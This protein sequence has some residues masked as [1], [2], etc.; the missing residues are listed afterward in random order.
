MSIPRFQSKPSESVESR[1]PALHVVTFGCQMN[2]YD[3]LSVEGR[4]KSQ[5]Y[6]TTESIGDADVVL[7]NTCSVRE[8]AEERVYSW[9][10]ELKK[11]K[12]RRPE[13]VV[14]VMGCMAERVGEELFG[15]AP[16][17]DLVVGTRSF[18]HLPELI[19]EVRSVRASGGVARITKLGLDEYPDGARDG[20]EYTGGRLGYLTVMRG[21]DLNCTFC[22]VPR[23]RGR[24]LSRP[25]DE[26]V[27]EARWMVERGAQ[28]ITL[29]GQ[30]V[31]SY[32]ED[33]PADSSAPMRGRQ[34]RPS[35]ADLLYRLQELDGLERIRLI[36]LHPSYVTRAL[37]EALRDCSKCDAFL[38][39]P[40]QAGSDDVLKRMKRGYT[41]DLY[42][43]RVDLLRELVPDI[44]LASDW[45]V[46]FP[47]ESD[48]DFE[49]TERFLG[50]QR[51]VTNYIFQYSPRPQTHAAEAHVDDVSAELKRERNHRL[52]ATAERVQLARFQQQIGRELDCFVERESEKH[53]GT[54]LGHTYTGLPISF[55]G[56]TTLI[57]SH[58]RI[59]V[60]HCT[61]FGLSGALAVTA[62]AAQA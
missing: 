37:A 26:L 25:I 3:S 31:N 16:I 18:Q 10:G 43:R 45:I 17:V 54:L 23:V 34:G 32:G 33:L 60:E 7:F 46:G 12:L 28:V 57:G 21:C 27:L 11:E 15:R 39:L 48:A 41:T 29:L 61:A 35:L 1:S 36:T 6:R 44:E 62:P 40:A 47:G 42:R 50:E 9:V 49:L 8:H 13:L 38:P 51:F 52:L 4:F 59:K 53:P 58:A 20:Q 24:V 14:G 2:K 22:I 30:T 5:G 56:D 55:R 19:D